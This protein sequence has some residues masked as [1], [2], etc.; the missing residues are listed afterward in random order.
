M[1]ELEK[2]KSLFQIL[3]D[4]SRLKI[5]KCINDKECSVNEIV[6]ATCL[7]QPLVSHHLKVMRDSEIVATKRSGPFI[8]YALKDTRLLQA[9][10]VFSEIANTINGE[11]I[12]EPI[13]FF[14]PMWR[15]YWHDKQ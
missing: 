1:E 15:K 9:L 2:L 10:G 3:G 12:E 5:I 8:F 11:V 13:F 4:A 14:P 7:S 6:E